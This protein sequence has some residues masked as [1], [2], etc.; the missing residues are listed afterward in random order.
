VRLEA[1][2]R[3]VSITAVSEKEAWLVLNLMRGDQEAG[4]EATAAVLEYKEISDDAIWP[5]RE[6]RKLSV[7]VKAG[8]V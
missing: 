5:P 4:D 1:S 8:C 2:W 3:R 7:V 6:K